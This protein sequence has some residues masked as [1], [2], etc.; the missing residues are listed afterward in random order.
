[1]KKI[2]LAL[3]LLLALGFTACKKETVVEETTTV[4]S[5]G[6]TTTTTTTT[7]DYDLKRLKAAEDEY[8]EAEREV[9]AAKER[10]DTKAERI[11]QDAADKAK[12]AWEVTKREV[13]E[14]G[15]KTEEALKEAGRDVKEGYNNALENAKAD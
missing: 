3:A 13:R 5:D 12:A 7:T 9:A 15:V 14:A 6:T 10:G 8:Y 11:A 4:H 2:T 1:M